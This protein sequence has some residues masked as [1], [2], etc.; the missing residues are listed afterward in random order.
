MRRLRPDT[1]LEI[2]L[3]RFVDWFKK[4]LRQLTG[5][6]MEPNSIFETNLKQIAARLTAKEFANALDLCRR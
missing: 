6:S 2:G 5:R 1:P 4:V 3:E